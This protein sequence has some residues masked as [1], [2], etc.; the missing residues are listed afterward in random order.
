M[1]LVWHIEAFPRR[2]H[3]HQTTPPPLFRFVNQLLETGGSN[4]VSAV[5]V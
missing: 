2:M 5:T 1:L 3:A 4:T